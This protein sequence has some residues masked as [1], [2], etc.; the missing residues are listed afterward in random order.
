MR[1]V[2]IPVSLHAAKPVNQM[3]QLQKMATAH[4]YRAIYPCKKTNANRDGSPLL[5]F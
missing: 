4:W 3:V 2:P 5:M 1:S